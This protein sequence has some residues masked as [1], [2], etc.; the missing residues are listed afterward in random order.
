MLAVAF[1]AF[2]MF[3]FV[4]DRSRA[5]SA[6][7]ASGV[8]R[9]EAAERLGFQR[10]VLVQF[11]KFAADAAARGSSASRTGKGRRWRR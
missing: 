6:Q 11:A 9:A 10:P 7:E 2:S 3:R 5:W 4:G 1:I 8:D